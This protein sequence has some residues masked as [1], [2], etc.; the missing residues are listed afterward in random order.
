MNIRKNTPR[1]VSLV[2]A[3]VVTV[4]LFQ[5]VATIGLPEDASS[6]Q[7]QGT[8]KQAVRVAQAATAKP[9]R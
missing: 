8:G 7:A 9:A 2:A 5:T 3:A 1:I 6:V 4:V